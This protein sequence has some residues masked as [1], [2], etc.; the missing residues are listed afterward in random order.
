MQTS[1][2]VE[3]DV[4]DLRK[5]KLVNELADLELTAVYAENEDEKCPASRVLRDEIVMI[6]YITQLMPSILSVSVTWF[7]AREWHAHERH[8]TDAVVFKG[9]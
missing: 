1:K 7:L 9:T 5:C 4:T 8:V 3:T 2:C 6:L